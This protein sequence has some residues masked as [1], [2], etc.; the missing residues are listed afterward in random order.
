MRTK[1]DV[2]V[3]MLSME[4]GDNLVQFNIFEVMKHP[5]KDHSLF[6][7]DLIDELVEEHL[8]LYTG[9][10]EISNFSRDIDVFNYLGYITD[11]A[12]YVKLWE[13]LNLSNS[14]DDIADLANLGHKAEFLDL[15][16]QVCK[17]EELKCS[18]SAEVQV[19]ETKKPLSAQQFPVIIANNL[20]QEQEEKLL[21]VLRQHKK[22]IGPS[23]KQQQRRLNPTILDVVNKEVTKLHAIGII[24]PISD[25]QWV[26]LVQVVPKKSGMTVMKNQHNKLVS[27][28]IQNSWRVCI[29]YRKLSQVT[30]KDH[31][32]L[33]FI[34]QV[35]EKLA[36]KSYYCFLDEFSGYMQICIA[37]EDQHKTIFTCAFGTFVYTRMLFGLCN[38]P[39]TFQ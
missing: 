13:V 21:H 37:P 22:A 3:G 33:P 36:G 26:T 32:P 9:S 14:E 17:H 6:G 10:D 5:T 39:S 34:D 31:F 4:F 20:H 29:D 8:Q 28:R 38:A 12:N 30:R 2:H 35:L 7:I 1:I 11:D 27:M 18:K 24:Y 25:S 19:A 16:D 15:V 23:N